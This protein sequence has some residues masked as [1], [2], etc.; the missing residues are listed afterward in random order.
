MPLPTPQVQTITYVVQTGDVAVDI[1][2]RF[3]VSTRDIAEANDINPSFLVVGQELLI[4]YELGVATDEILNVASSGTD[5]ST[6]GEIDTPCQ[7]IQYAMNQA[8]GFAE[9]R[10]GAGVYMERLEITRNVAL[11]GRGIENTILTGDFTNNVIT[12]N[13]NVSLTLAGITVTGGQ[14]EWGAGIINYGDLNLINVRISSNFADI[15]AGGIANIGVFNANN[16]EFVDNYAPYFPDIYNAQ[17]AVMF[18]DDMVE[19]AEETAIELIDD[20]DSALGVGMLVRVTTTEGDRLNMRS[21]PNLNAQN[22]SPLQDG[23]PLLII[24]G[25]EINNNFTWWQVQ[26]PLGTTGWV[27]DFAGEQTLDRVDSP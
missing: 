14:A 4:P 2:E 23:T 18:M 3:G 6:C 20:P 15:T 22:P 13:P 17:N 19:Y 26:S 5:I 21:A 12:V 7:T 1:A 24:G 8:N 16:V 10:I 27:V 11:A 9:I 25:P